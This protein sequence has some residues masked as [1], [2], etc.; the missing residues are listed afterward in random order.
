[1]KVCEE[2]ILWECINNTNVPVVM[3]LWMLVS[4]LGTERSD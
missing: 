4:G 2:R 3:Y 1:M